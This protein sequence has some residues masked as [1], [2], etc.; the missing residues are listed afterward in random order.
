MRPASRL[1]LAAALVA[2]PG[3]VG[4]PEAG[5]DAVRGTAASR[6]AAQAPSIAGHRGV[7]SLEADLLMQA[8]RASERP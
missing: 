7:A 2:A 3:P 4:S 5:R 8:P 6:P 1:A